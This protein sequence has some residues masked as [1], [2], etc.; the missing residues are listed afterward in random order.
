M[1]AVL[2]AAGF[3]LSVQRE[4]ARLERSGLVVVSR[5]GTQ[6]HFQANHAS[7]LFAELA[8][9]ARK[10]VGLA[11]PVRAALEPLARKIDAAFIYGSVAKRSDTASSDIDLMVLSESLAYAD[12]YPALEPVAEGLGRTIN[13][14]VLTRA[15]WARRL[16]QGRS[17]ATR[18]AAQDKIW[19]I[20]AEG[21]V[22]A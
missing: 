14:T 4:L 19:I 17:F 2:R 10:T 5:L 1:L 12:L 22:F 11:E 7:P 9:I 15:E 21:D 13:P 20:G 3:E 18:V 8:G 16:K 6:K